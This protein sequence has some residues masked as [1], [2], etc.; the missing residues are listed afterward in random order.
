M[1]QK[2]RRKPPKVQKT[3]LEKAGFSSAGVTLGAVKKALKAGQQHAELG[4]WD[5]ALPHLLVAWEAMPEDV[6]LLTLIAHGLARLGVREHALAVLER[7]LS[8]TEPSED[9]LNVMLNLAIEMEMH[10]VAVQVGELLVTTYPS[11]QHYV[12]LATAYTGVGKLD[13]SIEMLQQVLPLYPDSSDLWNVLATQVRARDGVAASNVFFEEAMRL[14]PKDLKVVSNYA[15]SFVQTG[16]FR[17]ALE[18]NIRAVELDPEVPEPHIGVAQLCFL[19]GQME[20]GWSHYKHRLNPRRTRNQTQI[21]THGLEAWEGQDLSGKTLMV[22]SEQGIGDEVM[23]GN[24]LPFLYERAEKLIIGCER[25]LLSLYQRR[26]PDA[27][28]DFHVDQL[29]QGYRYRHFPNAQRMLRDGEVQ[30]DFAISLADAPSFE[31]TATN[32]VK[33]HPDGFLKACP[34]RSLDIRKRLAAISSKP[35]V[36]FAWRSGIVSQQRNHLYGSIESFGPIMELADKVDFINLQYGEVTEELAKIK[37]LYGVDIHNFE[38]IDLKADI[39]ANV[40][41]ASNLD[42]VVSSCS[43]PGMF[44]LSSG[45]PTILTSAYTPWWCFGHDEKVLFAKDAEFVV[46][47]EI[48]DWDDIMKRV[49]SKVRG[50]LC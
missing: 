38:D 30:A 41:I 22:C 46:C 13:E 34:E 48:V 20:K 27:I 40:A 36:G 47:D 39:E 12:N 24:Y 23:F 25:R 26:F 9:I 42:L 29:K 2:N 10:S 45:S 28:V 37:A 11:A 31:W 19:E 16:K 3:K 35:K 1:Q 50:H 8:V 7:A 33:P 5:K 32:Q 49:A 44:S 4:E 6:H 43:A 15:I 17:K 14:S 18:L 21:Y